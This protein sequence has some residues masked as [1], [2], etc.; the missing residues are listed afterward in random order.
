[1]IQKALVLKTF[2]DNTAELSVQRQSACGGNCSGCGGCSSGKNVI[3]VIAD[4]PISAEK[5]QMV[6]VETKTS[7]IIRYAFLVYIIPVILL[8]VGYF[9]AS[10]LSLSEPL[11]ILI[12]FV[13]LC[14]GTVILHVFQKK[15][16]IDAVKYSISSV[17]EEHL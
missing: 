6:L 16:G 3:T 2:P 10:F 1:M 11:C 17:M 5:G 13:F 12:G 15:K 14:A 8:I 4:N 9:S 7:E